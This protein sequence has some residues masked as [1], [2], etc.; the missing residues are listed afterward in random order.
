M[1]KGSRLLQRLETL[2]RVLALTDGRDKSLKVV[3]YVLKVLLWLRWTRD[4][5]LSKSLVTQLSLSRRLIRLAHVL[6]PLSDVQG[7]ISSRHLPQTLN[8]GASL[9]SDLADDILC[10]GKLGILGDSWT[11]RAGLLSDRAWLLTILLDLVAAQDSLSRLSH[12]LSHASPSTE[13][14]DSD[15][16]KKRESLKQKLFL[17]RISIAKLYA[18]L[19]FCTIDV[20]DLGDRVSPG[21]QA[22]TGLTSALLGTYKLVLKVS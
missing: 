14:L 19:V 10:F 18:D 8:V 5:Q 21:W 2:R 16:E 1:T 12:A 15:L 9:L 7:V 4:L 6:E 17:Q 13:T 20:L 22:L 11:R 3:Q